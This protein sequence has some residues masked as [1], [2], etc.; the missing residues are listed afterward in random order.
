MGVGHCGVGVIVDRIEAADPDAI[1]L[2]MWLLI[3][4]AAV[5]LYLLAAWKLRKRNRWLPKPRADERS[6]IEQAKAH[7]GDRGR[8]G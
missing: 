4:A 1:L 5:G 3:C 8:Y 7:M 2:I 6:S